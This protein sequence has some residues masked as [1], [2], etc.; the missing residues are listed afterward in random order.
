MKM[1]KSSV[2]VNTYTN[3]KHFNFE[4]ELELSFFKGNLIVLVKTLQNPHC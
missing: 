1:S 2:K 3:I 4:N